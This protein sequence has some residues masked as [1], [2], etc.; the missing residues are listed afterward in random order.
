[1]QLGLEFLGVEGKGCVQFTLIISGDFLGENSFF[2][3]FCSL[4]CSL[5]SLL[6]LFFFLFSKLGI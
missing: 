6:S 4:F 5:L 1:M 3:F 2:N